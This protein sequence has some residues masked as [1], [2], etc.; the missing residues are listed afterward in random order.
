[1]RLP[2][3]AE[4]DIFGAP[5]VQ[6]GDG[7]ELAGGD[8][9]RASGLLFDEYFG[10]TEL[11]GARLLE[12]TAGASLW[13]VEGTPR[14]ALQTRGRYLDGWLTP[15]SQIRIWPTEHG[16]RRGVLELGFHLPAGA[17]V[18]TL[19]LAAPG[20]TRV[21]ELHPG[22][23]RSLLMPFE[24]RRPWTLSLRVDRPILIQGGRLVAVELDPPK[25]LEQQTNRA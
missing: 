20:A 19:R 5:L 22:E 11:E 1:V 17:P 9:T 10:P 7:G 6:I 23:S 2:G 18:Q 24:A 8:L 3:A 12:R 13:R 21:I 14:V 15:V 25:F 4:V 16:P